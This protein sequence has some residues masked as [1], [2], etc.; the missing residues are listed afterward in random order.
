MLGDLDEKFYTTSKKKSPF[1]A[2][3]PNFV[4]DFFSCRDSGARDYDIDGKLPGSLG[5]ENESR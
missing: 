2:R 4:V 5:G 1:K 3:D